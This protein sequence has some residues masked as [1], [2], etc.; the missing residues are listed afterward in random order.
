MLWRIVFAIKLLMMM[1][2]WET[3]LLAGEG[4]GPWGP[5]FRVAGRLKDIVYL[6]QIPWRWE[7]VRG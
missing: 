4:A 5:Q 1:T 6:I 2:L 3:Q 7:G